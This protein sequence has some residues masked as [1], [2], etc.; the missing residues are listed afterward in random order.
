MGTITCVRAELVLPGE[1]NR[2][3]V[4]LPIIAQSHNLWPHVIE[5]LE[6]LAHLTLNLPRTSS[7]QY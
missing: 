2:T 3:T 6:Q 5:I 4:H 1:V 7:T